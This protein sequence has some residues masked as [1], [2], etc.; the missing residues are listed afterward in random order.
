MFCKKCGKELENN[1]MYCSSCGE[2]NGSEITCEQKGKVNIKKNLGENVYKILL[3]VANIVVF[4]LPWVNWMET[5]MNF[6]GV[7]LL[8]STAEKLREGV[9]GI[10]SG[11]IGSVSKLM[12]L[13]VNTVMKILN[14]CWEDSGESIMFMQSSRWILFVVV[15]IILINTSYIVLLILGKERN[16]MMVSLII[17]HLIFSFV[18]MMITILIPSEVVGLSFGPIVMF[19]VQGVLGELAAQREVDLRRKAS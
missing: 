3:A 12:N 17:L 18:V 10:F 2:M 19:V 1:V 15:A 9:L 8:I 5:H 14:I 6:F 7:N 16:W 11:D 4:F 13:D